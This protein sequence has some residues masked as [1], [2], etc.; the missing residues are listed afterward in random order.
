MPVDKQ[1]LQDVIR[2]AVGDDDEMFHFLSQKLQANDQRATNFLAGFM[3]NKDYTQKSQALAEEKRTYDGNTQQWN[4]Q[5]NTYNTQ[6]DQYRQ[7]LEKAEAEKLAVL[8]DLGKER[9]SLQ[10]AYA[11]LQHIKD[12][13][14]L[15]DQDI[16]SYKDLIDTAKKGKPVDHSDIDID[17]KIS[18]LKKELT[19]YLAQKLIP[20][21]GGMAQLDIAWNDIREEHRELTG[22]RLT[23]KEQQ[24][25]LDEA[26]KRAQ[27]GRPISLKQLWEEKYDGP[28]LRLTKHDEEREKELR[29]KWDAEMVQKRSEEAMQGL[30]PN[31]PD[32]LRTSQILNHKFQT[33]EEGPAP[34]ARKVEARSSTQREAL[35][36]ADRA[37]KRFLERRAAGVPMG[38][39]DE[40]KGG[41][42]AA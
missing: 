9:E 7:M 37:A 25:L 13:Y 26:N 1:A 11:R 21:L 33:H 27:G 23:G 39:P 20:E 17:A 24:E 41:G 40:R 28:K 14:Q 32:G 30:H 29:T 34:L 16:P 12:I 6:L 15:S 5:L 35:G 8:R 4:T 3:R 42:K 31:A 38:A 18:G 19:D 22:K 36:G 10:G 2:E